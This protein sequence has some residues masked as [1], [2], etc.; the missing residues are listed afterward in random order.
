MDE[1]TDG[2]LLEMML[3]LDDQC[4]NMGW[5]HYAAALAFA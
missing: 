3:D 2:E 4:S 1:Q 5:N